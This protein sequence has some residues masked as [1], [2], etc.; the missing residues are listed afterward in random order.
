MSPVLSGKTR[1]FVSRLCFFRSC[2][3]TS[4]ATE[5]DAVRQSIAAQAVGTVYAA[6]DFARRVELGDNATKNI[7]D[8]GILIYAQS[9][10]AVVDGRLLRNRVERALDHGNHDLG[11]W[12]VEFGILSRF[13]VFIVL[14]DC[15]D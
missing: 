14:I 5:D 11:D 8:L 4:S 12:L 13:E 6:C 2:V 3:Y 7:H 1:L 15:I 10:H 9:P